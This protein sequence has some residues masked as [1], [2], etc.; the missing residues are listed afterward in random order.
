MSNVVAFSRPE[1]SDPHITGPAVCLECRHKWVAVAPVGTWHV[2]CPG[3]G[4]FKGVFDGL[5]QAQ[6]GDFAFICDCGCRALTAYKRAGL[7]HL[8]CMKCGV[9]HT[10]AVFG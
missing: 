10:E 5:C 8:V 9:D 6:E 2:E 7:F 3:C 1:P 4:T